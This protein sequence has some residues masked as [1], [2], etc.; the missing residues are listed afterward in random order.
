[1]AITNEFNE[2]RMHLEMTCVENHNSIRINDRVETVGDREDGTVA[3]LFPDGNLYQTV[4][5][6]MSKI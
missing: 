1:M 3:E 2:C 5:P 4:R 6:L